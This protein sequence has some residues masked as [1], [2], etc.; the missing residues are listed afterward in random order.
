MAATACR[1]ALRSASILSVALAGFAAPGPLLAANANAPA[2]TP[3]PDSVTGSGMTCPPN[4]LND[5]ESRMYAADGAIRSGPW[6]LRCFQNGIP[7]YD[8]D[9]I[10]VVCPKNDPRPGV[11]GADGHAIRFQFPADIACVWER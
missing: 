7:I 11:E 3:A 5:T 2:S 10:Y 9:R 1:R 4:Y 8:R 6:H